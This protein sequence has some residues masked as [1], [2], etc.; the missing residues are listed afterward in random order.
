[1]RTTPADAPEGAGRSEGPRSPMNDVADMGIAYV[2]RRLHTTIQPRST[3]CGHSD[4][5]MRVAR[6]S[7]PFRGRGFGDPLEC[8]REPWSPGAPSLKS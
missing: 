6:F 3:P 5:H 4:R 2:P 7:P 1:M 8:D